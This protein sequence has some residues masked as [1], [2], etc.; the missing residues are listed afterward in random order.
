MGHSMDGSNH[1]DK[2]IFIFI[3]TGS[4]LKYGLW[5]FDENALTLYSQTA[6][7][8]LLWNVESWSW[9]HLMYI[10]KINLDSTDYID[11]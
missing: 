8:P 9:A 4:G 11:I 6:V 3:Q 7:S 1:L 2:F 10:W 5:I